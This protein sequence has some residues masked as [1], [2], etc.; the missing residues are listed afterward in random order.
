MRGDG[1][2]RVMMMPKW[3]HHQKFNLKFWTICGST[4]QGTRVVII[5]FLERLCE[6]FSI[7]II[8]YCFQYISSSWLSN[9][10][11]LLGKLQYSPQIKCQEVTTVAFN[12]SAIYQLSNVRLA[13]LDTVLIFLWAK[14]CPKW[15][16]IKLVYQD[17][18]Q[19][20]KHVIN[21]IKPR[22]LV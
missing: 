7:K 3:F 17:G 18:L 9:R 2:I 19:P 1:L 20:N 10:H 11:L 5:F 15:K 22:V 4:T 21:N 12:I 14:L 13:K 8:Y 6:V 16:K